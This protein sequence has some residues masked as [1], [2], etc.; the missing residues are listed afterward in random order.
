MFGM[1]D[2]RLDTEGLLAELAFR[3]VKAARYMGTQALA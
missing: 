1:A 2:A 3:G